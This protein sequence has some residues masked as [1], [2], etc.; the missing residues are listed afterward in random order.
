MKFLTSAILSLFFCTVGSTQVNV[1]TL[2]QGH[3]QYNSQ[4][5]RSS[6]HFF[7]FDDGYH[8]FESDPNHSYS[9]LYAPYNVKVYTDDPYDTSAP[10]SL[11]IHTVNAG[12][13]SPITPFYQTEN[14][15]QLT[16]S[17]NLM[18]DRENYYVLM[19]QNIESNAPIDGCVEFHFKDSNTNVTTSTIKNNSF[20][21]WTDPLSQTLLPSDYPS[22]YTHKYKW[23]FTDLEYG[24]QRFIYIPAHCIGLPLDLIET[25]A[26]MKVNNCNNTFP[27]E[28]TPDGSL[29]GVNLSPLYTLSL[30][31]SSFPHDPN[32]IIVD[33]GC[34]SE[35]PIIETVRYKVYFQNDGT[36][37]AEYVNIKY[38]F[39]API[40]NV[41]LVDA[42]HTCDLSWTIPSDDFSIPE[43]LIIN[44]W[45]INLPGTGQDPSP[46]YEDTYGW[47]EIDVCYD[48]KV[49][50][51]LQQECVNTT[52][53]ILF[54]LQDP[55]LA[56]NELCKKHQFTPLTIPIN[57]YDSNYTCSPKY[58]TTQEIY[59][60][61]DDEDLKPTNTNNLSIVDPVVYPNPTQ[62]K[63]RIEHVDFRQID[64]IKIYNTQS[65][66]V[67]QITS[68]DFKN[69]AIIDVSEFESGVYYIVI[70]EKEMFKSVKFVKI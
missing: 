54:P 55:V 70:Q 56:E 25:R 63:L 58:L 40:V 65:Q 19:F 53:H 27:G 46:E 64:A 50:S 10:D 1:S 23:T 32:C 36:G 15:V 3:F 31:V 67:K 44:Y 14:K 8:S 47:F 21:S 4:L 9:P 45:D 48:L 38:E 62:D 69:S 26:V 28:S 11:L 16:E 61:Q 20:R 5:Q 59:V 6:L 35:S 18:N 68:S 12:D 29:P 49:F 22:E 7:L 34:L 33:P 41:T 13:P 24:E 2:S 66:L 42:S 39:D 17:W 30:R 52:A 60:E 37:P 57:C 43:P 51:V